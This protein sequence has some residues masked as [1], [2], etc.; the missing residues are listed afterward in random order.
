[1]KAI[2]LIEAL[3]RYKMNSCRRSA[4]RKGPDEIDVACCDVGSIS[5]RG[6]CLI[7]KAESKRDGVV[8]TSRVAEVK[9]A[10]WSCLELVAHEH[11]KT[12]V[13]GGES[14]GLYVLMEGIQEGVRTTVVASGIFDAL[15]KPRVVV[16]IN[17]IV[18]VVVK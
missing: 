12:R 8:I 7:L 10:N 11:W 18:V 13:S 16:L 2:V 9:E 15:T 3:P 1:L 14:G 4:K 5:D 17:A 6:P